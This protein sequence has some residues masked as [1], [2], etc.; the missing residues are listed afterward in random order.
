MFKKRLLYFKE[1]KAKRDFSFFHT[2]AE[3]FP[4]E[5][6]KSVSESFFFL[7]RN[8]SLNCTTQLRCRGKKMFRLIKS[9][10]IS[11]LSWKRRSFL[12][13]FL[14]KNQKKFSRENEKKTINT[15]IRSF[16][17]SLCKKSIPALFFTSLQKSGIKDKTSIQILWIIFC[18]ARYIK[19]IYNNMICCI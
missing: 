19:I 15:E 11:H 16:Q 3:A 18:K 12:T 2:N 5:K 13:S 10:A 8:R 17:K 14:W 6:K 7:Q 9:F 4:R 1:L